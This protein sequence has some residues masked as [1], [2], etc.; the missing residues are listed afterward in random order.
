MSAFLDRLVARWSGQRVRHSSLVANWL[1]VRGLLSDREW[2]R[3]ARHGIL[4]RRAVR[5]F[6]GK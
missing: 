1:P 3:L 4:R 6:E 5:T 2:Q